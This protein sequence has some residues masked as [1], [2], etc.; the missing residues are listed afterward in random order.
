MEV[1]RAGRHHLVGV[2]Q[3]LHS[4]FYEAYSD[5]LRPE[6]IAHVLAEDY[7]PSALKR[8]MLSGGLIVA[9]DDDIVVGCGIAEIMEDH[10]DVPVLVVDPDH[11]H[12][13]VGNSILQALRD[14]DA[15]VPLC[16]NVLLGSI[17]GETFVESLGFVPGETIERLLGRE[18]IV[19]RRWWLEAA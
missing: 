13:G 16:V 14:L 2:S 7:S 15:S 9:L 5:L 17:E 6:T 1:T 11:R 3:V 18:Q 12:R 8:R 19:E 4:A 10:V